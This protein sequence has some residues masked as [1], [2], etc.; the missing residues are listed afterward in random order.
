VITAHRIDKEKARN[1]KEAET[2]RQTQNE[3]QED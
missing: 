1:K 3:H 2:S